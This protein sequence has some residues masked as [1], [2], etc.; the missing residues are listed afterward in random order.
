MSENG[1]LSS[2]LYPAEDQFM[3]CCCV[4]LET[5]KKMKRDCYCFFDFPIF[6]THI[7][8]CRKTGLKIS[9]V[10]CQKYLTIAEADK[11]IEKELRDK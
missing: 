6:G 9:C 4:D 1:T 7:Y 8:M 5:E 10:D 11:I 2:V 3:N